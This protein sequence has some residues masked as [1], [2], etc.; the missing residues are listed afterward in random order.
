MKTIQ[1]KPGKPSK[2]YVNSK[3]IGLNTA[4]GMYQKG[5]K[6]TVNGK[7]INLNKFGMMTCYPLQLENCEGKMC[8]ND[9]NKVLPVDIKS[10]F[11]TTDA[12]EN[13]EYL[14][15][16]KANS[17]FEI[18]VAKDPCASTDAC[19]FNC[20]GNRQDKRRFNHSCLA[21]NEDILCGGIMTYNNGSMV[22]DNM[23]GHY[24]PERECLNEVLVHLIKDL[25][26]R[27]PG[28]TTND[29]GDTMDIFINREN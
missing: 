29:Y 8:Y 22:F 18:L 3:R 21:N 2:F 9:G 14:W 13:G 4:F 24:L 26:N 17:P 28:V 15:V 7:K 20:D 5:A 12:L 16:I 10:L 27:I 11:K 19:V 23:S 6:F 25:T 1:V